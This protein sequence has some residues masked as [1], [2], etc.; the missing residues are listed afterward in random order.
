MLHERAARQDGPTIDGLVLWPSIISYAL[1]IHI[2]NDV[3]ETDVG[4]TCAHNTACKLCI[5]QT[6]K[7]YVQNAAGIISRTF[8][9]SR[10]DAHCL[11]A[12]T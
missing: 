8:A 7:R 1:Y 11:G 3:Q 9:H 5:L 2:M 6:F 10:A 4:Q 12:Q